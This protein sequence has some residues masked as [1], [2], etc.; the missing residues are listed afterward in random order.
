MHGVLLV[1]CY[2]K[3]EKNTGQRK[4]YRGY[5]RTTKGFSSWKKA[6]QCFE[7]HQ[8]THCHKSAASYHVAIPKCKD[9]GE[10]TNNNLVNLREKGSKYSL[11]VIRC[12]LY[13]GIAL[14]GNENNDNFTALMMLLGT[15]FESRIAHLDGTIGNKYTHHD[16][17]NEL[18]NIMSRH[19]LLS[20]L[21]TIRKIYLFIFLQ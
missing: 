11:D 5:I 18:L 10:M 19:V 15:K 6:P 20:K 8:Y 12:L 7:E 3:K 4:K 9:V 17:Q 2:A 1:L 14:Q 21:E 16:I 13:Q